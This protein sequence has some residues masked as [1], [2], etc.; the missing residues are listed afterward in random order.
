MSKIKYITRVKRV[1][2]LSQKEVEEL[3]EV[4]Q[5]F[6]FRSNSYY[7][8]LI[9]W[10]DPEDPIRKLVIPHK[11]ELTDW[12]D[13]DASSEEHYTEARGLE[14]KYQDTALILFNNICGAYC[15]YCFRKRLFM[16]GNDDTV[17]DMAEAIAYIKTHSEISNVLI[18]GGDPLIA[19]TR[20]IRPFIESLRKID[21]VKIIRFGTKMT[22]FNPYRLIED[23]ALHE[24]IREFSTAD[25]RIYIMNHFTHPRELTEPAIE[26]IN[27]L[28]KSGAICINQAPML[29]GIN[30]NVDTL[31]ELFEKL[32]EIGVPPYYVFGVRP[33]LGNKPYTV[34]IETISEIFEK[35]RVR[36]SG[37]AARARFVMSH[38]SGKIE[39]LGMTQDKI[40][41]RYH[42]AANLEERGRVMIYKRNPEALWFDDYKELLESYEL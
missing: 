23:E 6:V 38:K 11:D 18:T 21:H 20:K 25:K 15:R 42:R 1:E 31:K 7:N 8:S 35:A 27:K 29:K 40:I 4:E 14:H 33:T 39:V 32:S 9:D 24:M 19:S 10:S 28:I 22:A 12:G 5:K 17:E 30:D 13:L 2:Q 16:D 36:T 34:P 3:Q 37:L 41:F 26:A